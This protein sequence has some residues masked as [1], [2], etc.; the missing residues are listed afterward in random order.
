[1]D[2]FTVKY[3]DKQ[4]ADHLRNALLCSYE[5]TTDWEG[6]VYSGMTL[7][8]YYKN[9][10][11]DIYM[12]GY[13]A[14]VLSKFQKC[15]PK[16]PQYTPSRYF[17]PVY[18]AKTQD[19]TQDETPPLT[20]NQCLNIQKVTGSVLYYAR[21]VE[22]TVLMPINDIATEQIR[23]TEKTQASTNQLLDYLATHPDA[24]IR[25]HA[26][27]MIIHTHSDASHLPVSHALSRLGGLLFCGDKPKKEDN[28]N[29]S[30]LNMASVIKKLVAST[31]ES[32][33]GAC[34]QNA[35]S[36]VPFKITIIERG[37]KQ[38]ATSLRTDNSTAFGILDETIKKKGQKKWTL[39]TIG[40]QIE[41]A[42]K[43]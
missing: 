1:V 20:A 35:Q 3:V 14:N 24:T 30:I 17:M 4:H 40:S 12:P 18:G 22:K 5:L 37:H 26:S 13:V 10:T 41:S 2:D 23:A 11:C 7:K 38:P 31:P 36:G 8:W 9:I 6:K 42:T 15:K 27:D 19:A 21:E 16:H 33:L 34:F 25:Y 32:E 43:N 39:D 29:G 28:L